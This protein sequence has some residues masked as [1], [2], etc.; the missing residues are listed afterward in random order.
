[1]ISKI[2]KSFV[3]LLAFVIGIGITT[4]FSLRSGSKAALGRIEI[5]APQKPGPQK[6]KSEQTLEMVF[7]IDTTGSMGGLIE[8]AKRRVWSIINEVMQE[9]YSPEVRVGLVAYRDRGDDYVSRVTPLTTDLDSVYSTLIDFRAQGGG[10]WPEDVKRA[11]ID[12]IDKPRWARSS[13][14]VTKVLFLVGDAPPHDDYLDEPALSAIISNAVK[15]NI[16]VN[17]IQCGSAPDTARVW[18]DIAQNGRGQYFA[19]PQNGGVEQVSTPYD[20]RLAELSRKLGGT[21]IAYGMKREDN[22]VKQKAHETT[23]GYVAGNLSAA[24]NADRAVNKAI[25]RN[26][27]DGDLLQDIENGV[28]KIDDV[29]TEEL[30]DDLR[31]MKPPERKA[32]IERRLE[33]RK[34][35][36]S[37]ILDLTKQRQ[38]YLEEHSG[39]KNVKSNS[40]DSAVVKA[41]LQEMSAK[42]RK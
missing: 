20:D 1:M 33:E 21:Y 27:Y 14:G 35:I 19:I 12:G 18:R 36:R 29:K 15:H 23:E 17:S 40:F 6:R 10:D 26:A 39:G 13:D 34:K 5:E 3:A 42:T 28:K 11:L 31:S 38:K 22:E 4:H 32:E 24:T 7:V 8:G 30:P 37:E 16:I 41:L 25:N 9:E 2:M